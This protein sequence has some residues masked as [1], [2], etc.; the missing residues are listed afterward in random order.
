MCA[1]KLKNEN[2]LFLHELHILGLTMENEYLGNMYFPDIQHINAK[3]VTILYNGVYI[4]LRGVTV[5]K[6]I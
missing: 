3:Y 6:N 2:S 1:Y 5:R 4:G